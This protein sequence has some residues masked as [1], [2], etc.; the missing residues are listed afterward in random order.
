M[1][2]VINALHS[3]EYQQGRGRLRRGNCFC[4]Q[5]VI[6]DMVARGA[7]KGIEGHWNKD[8]REE[9]K[10]KGSS[11]SYRLTAESIVT[12]VLGKTNRVIGNL[13]QLNDGLQ[14]LLN[15]ETV[16]KD[17]LF[18]S[19]DEIADILQMELYEQGEF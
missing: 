4:V 17:S 3:G 5:G 1:K 19:F 11:E 6:C 7:F 10:L 13:W 12:R 9:F 16:N 18:Y 15:G 8:N 14:Y 2:K